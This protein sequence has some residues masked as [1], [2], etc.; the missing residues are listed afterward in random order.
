MT[1]D[2][3][4]ERAARSWIEAGP[5]RAPDH[6]VEAALQLIDTTPQERDLPRR[7]TMPTIAR[8]AAAAAIGVLLVG[9]ALFMLGSPEQTGVGG[10]SVS[11]SLAPIP[12]PSLYPRLAPS[13]RGRTTA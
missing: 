12:S 10:P 8:V 1:D 13:N 2:R 9:G 5:T 3:S 4:L 11:P 6:V 7:I